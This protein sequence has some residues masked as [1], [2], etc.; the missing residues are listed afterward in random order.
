M[1]EQSVNIDLGRLENRV[2]QLARIQDQTNE[3][4]DGMGREITQVQKNLSELASRFEQLMREQ[5]KIA[6]LQ[7]ATTELVRVRQE[8][9]SK[10]GDYKTNNSQ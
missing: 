5:K 1:S 8:I 6:A 3:K 10:F 7:Q 2:E 4:L 9:D